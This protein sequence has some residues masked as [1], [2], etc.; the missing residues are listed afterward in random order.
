MITAIFTAEVTT[1]TIET[2]EVVN[3][4][5]MGPQSNLIRLTQGTH[6]LEVEAGVFKVISN[7]PVR[8]TADSASA[9][10]ECTLQDKD[11]TFP[12]QTILAKRG[13]DIATTRK[14]FVDAKSMGP[15]R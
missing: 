15:P 13:L 8:V 4:E 9:C 6:T 7:R 11:G 1:L 12:D 5:Q 2:V 3:L 14:F 10:I